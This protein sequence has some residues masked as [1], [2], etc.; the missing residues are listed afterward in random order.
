MEN[1]LLDTMVSIHKKM[2]MLNWWDGE[3]SFQIIVETIEADQ[4]L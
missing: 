1:S 2:K 3:D 4:Q